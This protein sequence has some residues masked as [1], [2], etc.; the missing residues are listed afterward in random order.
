[1]PGSLLG[2][3]RRRI[4]RTAF[5]HLRDATEINREIDNLDV[6]ILPMD[7]VAVSCVF[8]F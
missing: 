4:P 5:M 7:R 1:M 3:W 2:R 8:Y 6:E